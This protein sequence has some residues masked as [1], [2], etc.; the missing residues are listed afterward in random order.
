MGQGCEHHEQVPDFDF[1]VDVGQHGNVGGLDGKIDQFTAGGLEAICGEALESQQVLHRL[2]PALFSFLLVQDCLL[3]MLRPAV[4]LLGGDGEL[5][6]E[7]DVVQ[8]GQILHADGEES[9]GRRE[10]QG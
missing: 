9:K 10:R 6:G 2:F 1:N 8:H 5:G 4:L 3:S 7:P